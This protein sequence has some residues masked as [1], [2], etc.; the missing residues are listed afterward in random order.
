MFSV[1]IWDKLFTQEHFIVY[2][3]EDSINVE[4]FDL[5]QEL[6]VTTERY[7]LPND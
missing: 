1:I 3:P 4:I 6:T 7:V 2:A 5:D